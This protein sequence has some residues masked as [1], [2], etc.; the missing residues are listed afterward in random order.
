MRGEHL[1][2]NLGVCAGGPRVFGRLVQ[3]QGSWQAPMLCPVPSWNQC[4]SNTLCLICLTV[5]H[6]AMFSCGH[7]LPGLLFQVF[8]HSRPTQ[9]LQTLC[10]LPTS[11]YTYIPPPAWPAPAGVLRGCRSPPPLAP[12]RTMLYHML[13][14]MFSSGHTLSNPAAVIS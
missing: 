7:T 4:S 12:T 13:T 9:T 11:P 2:A 14:P 1:F 8:S 6:T 5:H 3:E 10:A